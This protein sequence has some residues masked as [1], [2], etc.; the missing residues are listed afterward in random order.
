MPPRPPKPSLFLLA[1]ALLPSACFDPQVTGTE[2]GSD[3]D[4]TAA[5]TDDGMTTIEPDGSSGEPLP[6]CGNGVIEG[7]EACD[8]EVNDGSYGGCNADCTAPGPFCGDGIVN[9]EEPCDDG[10]DVDGNGCNVN[11]VVSGTVLWTVTY[12]GPEHGI[13][14]PDGVT[15]DSEGNVIVSGT[16]SGGDDSRGWL[17]KYSAE[18]TSQWTVDITAP[19]GPTTNGPVATLLDDDILLGGSYGAGSPS[20]DAWLRRYSDGGE[21]V[22]TQPYASPQEGRDSV[23]DI[24]IDPDGNIYALFDEDQLPTDPDHRTFIRKYTPEGTELWTQFHEPGEEAMH[25]AVDGQGRRVVA[26]RS[27]S[28]GMYETWVRQ[29]TSDGSEI[30]SQFLEDV[31]TPL[32][33]SVNH[34]GMIAVGSSSVVVLMTPDGVE[35]SV[36]TPHP[37]AVLTGIYSTRLE[38]DGALIVG[39]T[40]ITSGDAAHGWVSKYDPSGTELWTNTYD[41]GY[42]SMYSWDVV[43]SVTTDTMGNVIATGRIH[44][45]TDFFSNIWL[46]KIAP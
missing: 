13:D 34:E 17:R 37:E 16:L 24:D 18:G 31:S 28:A 7:D 45:S 10:D 39:G 33:I 4:T 20:Q 30:W 19:R 29:E 27:G 23:K 15:T 40:M 41:G 3:G 8:D 43:L 22:W 35:S 38:D 42:D 21:A 9:G 44:D 26:G 6:V 12:D 5:M 25:L 14:S 46:A 32:D 2:D 36:L 1:L 11:C